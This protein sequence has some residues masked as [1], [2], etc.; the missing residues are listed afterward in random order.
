MDKSK[1]H[2]EQVPL[3]KIKQIINENPPR[4]EDSES[5]SVV[6]EAPAKKTEPYSIAAVQRR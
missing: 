5:N 1:T 4:K 6:A 3:E 2:F